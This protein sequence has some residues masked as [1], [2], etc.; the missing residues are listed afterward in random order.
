[1]VSSRSLSS[2]PLPV[3]ADQR[4]LHALQLLPVQIPVLQR[5]Q[6]PLPKGE[7]QHHVSVSV[8]PESAVPPVIVL[9][10]SQTGCKTPQCTYTGLHAHHP[11]DC[12]FYLRDWEPHRLQALL[13]VLMLLLELQPNMFVLF[14]LPIF[15]F[16]FI[17]EAASPSTLILLMEL[18]PVKQLCC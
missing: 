11:R 17:R 3:R 1:M 10:V 6:Q 2:L 16:S 15:T 8:L 5:L 13:Q 12:L 7:M 4:R 9:S 18:K 14:K